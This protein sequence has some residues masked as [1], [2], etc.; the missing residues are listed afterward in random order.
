[1]ALPCFKIV[2]TDC[3]TI[4]MRLIAFWFNIISVQTFHSM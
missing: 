1:M 4:V 3:E 2:M